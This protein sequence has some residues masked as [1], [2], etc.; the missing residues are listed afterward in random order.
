MASHNKTVVINLVEEEGEREYDE[1]EFRRIIDLTQE[2][3]NDELP[4]TA[5]YGQ[6][7]H[8]LRR[9]KMGKRNAPLD[10]THRSVRAYSVQGIKYRVNDFV[11][12][13]QPVGAFW[14][15]Q[16]VEVKQI[17][18]NAS[19]GGGG[20][21]DDD[22]ILLRGLPYAR[23]SDMGG[24]FERRANEVCQLLEIDDDDNRPDEQQAMIEVR[25]RE[26]L[27]TRVFH[28]TNT[29]YHSARNCR[30][31][32]DP[33]WLGLSKSDAAKRQRA[34][35]APLTCRWKMRFDRF[36]KVGK[37][38]GTAVIHLAE[39]DIHDPNYRIPDEERRRA[40]L[41]RY[42]GSAGGQRLQ[43]TFGD[44][45][46]GCG[47]ASSGARQAGLEVNQTSP[48]PVAALLDPNVSN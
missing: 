19:F 46:C 13:A 1:E 23:N 32:N 22:K 4:L 20:S 35:L 48:A 31:G 5:Q 8:G 27:T 24:R 2:N 28:K 29:D 17:W 16:F 44:A 36:R 7:S 34:D 47:G 3:E 9:P 6:Q 37:T 39:S 10:S 30:F 43:V 18:V 40:W 11:E 33:S 14:R 26:I 38:Y 41:K 42:P 25:P 12:L 21:G 15:A 45:F